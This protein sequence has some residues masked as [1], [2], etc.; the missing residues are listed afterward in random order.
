M[1]LQLMMTFLMTAMLSAGHKPSFFLPSNALQLQLFGAPS[2]TSNSEW[3]FSVV[4]TE[5]ACKHLMAMLKQEES[6]LRNIATSDLKLSNGKEKKSG[7]LPPTEK[8]KKRGR[9]NKKELENLAKKNKKTTTTKKS[10][11]K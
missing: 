7:V 3:F 2:S 8:S 5:T 11:K 4:K 6:F 10:S 9:T 1:Q